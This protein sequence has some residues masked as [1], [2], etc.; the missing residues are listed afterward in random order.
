M[1]YHDWHLSGY[2]VLDGGARIVL[3]LLW[4]YPPQ[5]KLENHI[6]F[7]GVAAYR[8]NHTDGAIITDIEEAPVEEYFRFEKE[9]ITWAAKQTGLRYWPGDIDA[10]RRRLDTEG[11]KYWSIGSAIGFEG[12]VVAKAALELKSSEVSVK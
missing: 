5:E 1:R 2:S 4:N 3:H 10:Y 7:A 6:Q 12:F 8:F 9:F 11:F